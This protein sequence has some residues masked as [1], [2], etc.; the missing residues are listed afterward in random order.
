L[1]PIAD[2]V[3]GKRGQLKLSGGEARRVSIAIALINQPAILFLDEITSGLDSHSAYSVMQYVSRM[4]RE[5]GIIAICNIHQPRN[6]IFRMFDSVL[7]LAEG[8]SLY[9]G[10]RGDLAGFFKANN[11]V[12][13]PD[14]MPA[15]HLLNYAHKNSVND[16]ADSDIRERQGTV[17][18]SLSHLIVGLSY[19]SLGSD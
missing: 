14:V 4:C 13:P 3:I 1:L 18:S 5:Q 9:F 12:C 10:A 19:S 6:D 16:V 8:K 15:D 17:M 7:L 2:R 11:F